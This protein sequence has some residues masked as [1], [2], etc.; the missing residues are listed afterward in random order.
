M[1]DDHRPG[2]GSALD[3]TSALAEMW[4]LEEQSS[5]DLD[6]LREVLWE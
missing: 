6:L 2:T 4:L 3:Q 5:N 1:A